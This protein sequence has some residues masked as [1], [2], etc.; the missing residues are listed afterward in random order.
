[1]A[2]GKEQ[3]KY[4]A[5]VAGAAAACSTIPSGVGAIA[6]GVALYGV[7]DALDD[8]LSCKERAEEAAVA[9]AV[10]QLVEKVK[11]EYERL[12]QKN[13]DAAKK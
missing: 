4:V 1:M 11:Q 2:C 5:A 13:I 12:Q 10:Q 9:A 3:G 6:C 8:L 7:A